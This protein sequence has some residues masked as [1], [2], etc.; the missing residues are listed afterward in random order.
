MIG[1]KLYSNI[2]YAFNKLTSMN[3]EDIISSAHAGLVARPTWLK[4]TRLQTADPND[5]GPF[6]LSLGPS[7]PPNSSGGLAEARHPSAT[8]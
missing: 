4:G 7:R 1:R 3:T 8:R 5:S 6:M 2:F